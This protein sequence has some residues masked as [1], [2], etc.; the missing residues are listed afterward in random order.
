LLELGRP[1]STSSI[2][3]PASSL[4]ASDPRSQ[5]PIPQAGHTS[6]P[7]APPTD[8]NAVSPP[9]RAAPS[10][11][12]RANEQAGRAR[13]AAF[14]QRSSGEIPAIARSPASPMWTVERGQQDAPP[15]PLAPRTPHWARHVAAQTL[16]YLGLSC[17]DLTPTFT[18]SQD[19][20]GR[21]RPPRPVETG[22]PRDHHGARTQRSSLD[23]RAA[24]AGAG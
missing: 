6:A 19:I 7:R 18:S 5:A 11:L 3:I 12:F 24:A 9:G 20:A 1:C 15:V 2:G 21:P 17:P 8:E 14:Q 23:S 10:L 16:A 4:L 22:S 13:P